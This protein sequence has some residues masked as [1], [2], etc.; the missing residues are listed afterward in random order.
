[1][2]VQNQVLLILISGYNEYLNLLSVIYP[3]FV[4]TIVHKIEIIWVPI[5]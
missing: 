2:I 3:P 5:V 4:M 1:M